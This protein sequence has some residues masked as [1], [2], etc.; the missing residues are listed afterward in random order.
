MDANVDSCGSAM[1]SCA[2]FVASAETIHF[3]CVF[4][5]MTFFFFFVV[6]VVVFF[7]N[8]EDALGT[9]ALAAAKLMVSSF[10]P[11][12]FFFGSLCDACADRRV[13]CLSVWGCGVASFSF[14]ISRPRRGFD[15][16]PK[17]TQSQPL[18]FKML[19]ERDKENNQAKKEQKFIFIR[20]GE[21]VPM[22]HHFTS[23]LLS[24]CTSLFLLPLDGRRSRN[25]KTRLL[26][27]FNARRDRGCAQT[28]SLQRVRIGKKMYNPTRI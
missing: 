3:F 1:P 14:C 24:A 5:A 16:P 8:T 9:Q 27:R 21:W 17:T 20:K 28:H 4:C 7:A 2:C 10:L 26:R 25:E 13:S 6:V 18:A 22:F 12:L 23:S 11:F 19:E 15:P